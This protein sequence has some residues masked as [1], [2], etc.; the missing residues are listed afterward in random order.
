[1]KLTKFSI[2][3]MSKLFLAISFSISETLYVQDSTITKS[4]K[5]S[6]QEIIF[7]P[8]IKLLTSDKK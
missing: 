4:L 3:E 2:V 5:L 7:S 8:T 6:S 1:M